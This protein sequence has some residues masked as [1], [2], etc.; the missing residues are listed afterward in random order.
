MAFQEVD[1]SSTHYKV[2]QKQC[3]HDF[4]CNADLET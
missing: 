4:S 2:P 1:I 3:E